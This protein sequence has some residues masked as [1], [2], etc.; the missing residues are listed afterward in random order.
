VTW[1]WGNVPLPEAHLVGLGAGIV[2]QVVAPWR[3]AWP[4][5]VGQ[6]T[7]WPL[8][9][10]GLT[11]GAWAVRVAGEVDLEGPDRLVRHG[12]YRLSRNP[13]YVAWTLGYLGVALVAGAVWLLVLLPAVAAATQVGVVREERALERRFGDAYRRYRASV[14]RYL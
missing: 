4:G 3:L 14:R 12:P 7:G 9:L 13:M 5:W 2:L 6:A 11:L 1:R 10:A 8:L